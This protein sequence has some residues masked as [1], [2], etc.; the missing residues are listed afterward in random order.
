M[1]IKTLTSTLALS[2]MLVGPAAVAMETEEDQK[3]TPR[4]LSVE[5]ELATPLTEEDWTKSLVINP[6]LVLDMV[7]AF[8]E[9]ATDDDKLAGKQAAE[10]VK[11]DA[12]ARKKQKSATVENSPSLTS[13]EKKTASWLFSWFT[14][15]TSSEKDT[16]SVN[17][18]SL[19]VKP[20]D[21]M[22]T[23]SV[24]PLQPETALPEEVV[25]SS[26]SIFSYLNPL[27]WNWGSG[28]SDVEVK[29]DIKLEGTDITVNN[30]ET[31]NLATVTVNNETEPSNSEKVD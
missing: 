23:T 11:Q 20:E 31:N 14:S 25:Q 1:E 8:R 21:T 19:E 29:L 28:K 30:G 27:H 5:G 3:G 4:T 22:A 17:S 18:T 13:E 9:G 26:S 2:V 24:Q 10:L 12:A 6:H 16:T 7:K 15:E